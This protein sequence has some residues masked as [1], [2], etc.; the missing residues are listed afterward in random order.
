MDFLFLSSL[1]HLIFPN[2]STSARLWISRTWA[3][4][5]ILYFLMFLSVR[6]CGFHTPELA[7]TS[8]I[9]W[10]FHQ[11]ALV[12]FMYLSY[13]SHLISWC[14]YQ[15]TVVDFILSS[16]SHLIFPD[17]STSAR[18]WISCTCAFFLFLYFLT[19]LP[20]RGGGFHTPELSCSFY[21]SWCFYQCAVVDFMHLSFLSHLIFPDFSTSARS[22]ISYAWA[23]LRI[24][25]SAR[26]STSVFGR[27]HFY[28]CAVSKFHSA[29]LSFIA[30]LAF[31]F[32][33]IKWSFFPPVPRWW[34]SCS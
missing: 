26:L 4:F 2:V 7:S 9:S 24:S 3:L 8:Y 23:L 16:L 32:L 1:S 17:A 20:V 30:F 14:F 15:C 22:R 5:H 12:D 25:Y 27:L 6:V 18:L 21:I 10:C 33:C 34:I 11:C 31:F 29:K 13:L 28:R 19:F